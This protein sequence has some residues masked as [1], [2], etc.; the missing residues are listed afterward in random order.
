MCRRGARCKERHVDVAGPSSCVEEL[1]LKPCSVQPVQR[2]CSL[3]LLAPH[4][5]TEAKESCFS[6]QFTEALPSKDMQ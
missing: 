1:S 5:D 6:T 4:S 3:V 2:G